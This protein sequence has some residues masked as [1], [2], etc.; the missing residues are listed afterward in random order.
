MPA[1]RDLVV[2]GSS[3]GGVEAL[4]QVLGCFPPDFGAAVCIVQHLRS[5]A[6]PLLVSIL[7]RST[8]LAVEWA[9]QGA[10]VEPG[11]V[12]VAPPDVHTLFSD[13]H[14]TLVR[15]PRENF[16]RPSINK[17]FR[18]AAAHYGTRAIGVLLT[19]M[20]DDGVSGLCSIR[21]NGGVLVVQ[22][23]MDAMYPELPMRALRAVEPDQVLPLSSIGLAIIALV[24][25]RVEQRERSP[26]L[27]A[28][29]EID[30]SGNVDPS[31]LEMIA[32]RTPI[33]C[34]DCKGPTWLVGEPGNR[35]YR[36][37]HGHVSAA[38]DLLAQES[39]EIESALWSAVRALSDR[40]IT[41]ETLANDSERL[42]RQRIANTYS[43]RAREARGH[44]E[45]VRKFVLDVLRL[46][47][48]PDAEMT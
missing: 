33:P 18:S 32:N 41:L 30:R 11:H 1:T 34:P 39:L 14:L 16:S 27:A 46:E 23:P 45:A 48:P 4:P 22:D 24:G 5:S 8:P 31:T 44:A 15:G 25:Q 7:R 12:Y 36:C 21:D 17:T 47:F 38:Q 6:D 40:A 19:G 26:Q 28:E 3:A 9:E 43:D 29:A 13:D 2:I 10:R 42:G 37:Y 35:R 20:L